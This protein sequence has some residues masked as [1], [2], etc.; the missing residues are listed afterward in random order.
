[1]V[2]MTAL[3]DPRTAAPST[4]RTTVLGGA[5]GALAMVFVGASVAVSSTLAGAPVDTAQALRYALACLLL[6]GCAHRL[7][8]PVVRPRGRE[9]LWLSAVAVTG[10]VVFNIALVDGSRHAEPAV[11]AVGVA[12]VPL[13]FAIVGPLQQRRRPRLPVIVAAVLVT[14]GAIL[15]DGTGRTDAIGIGWAVVVFGCEAG[16]T[17]LAVPVLGR[18]GAWGVSVHTT[19][20][21]AVA[22]AMLAIL[23]EGPAAAARL[24][25]GH[26]LA[27]VYLAVAVTA[28]AFVLW[29]TS[30]SRLGAGRAG[31]FTGIAP[32]SAAVTGILLGSRLPHLPVW[33]GIATVAA[34]LVLGLRPA[35]TTP[36]APKAG[37]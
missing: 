25:S 10:M 11:L 23:R 37:D 27:V 4:H 34:G 5:A 9:W 15:V 2:T 6:I 3:A 20:L 36:A 22:F 30:V 17:L 1:M 26:V 33:L 7:G 28:M 31:L 32:A 19:W 24:D 14:A 21:A 29:Y 12:C 16:F 8:R 13:L 35:R 18:L